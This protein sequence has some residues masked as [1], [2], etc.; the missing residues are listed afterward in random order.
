[1]DVIPGAPTTSRVRAGVCPP[2]TSRTWDGGAGTLEWSAATNWSGDALPSASDQVCI[3]LG[4]PGAEVRVAGDRSIAG[5]YAEKPLVVPTGSLAIAQASQVSSLTLGTPTTSADLSTGAELRVATLVWNGGRISGSGSLVETSS[6]TIAGPRMHSLAIPFTSNGSTVV[7]ASDGSFVIEGSTTWTNNG[8]LH[9]RGGGGVSDDGGYVQTQLVNAPGSRIERLLLGTP[10]DGT[11]STVGVP[12]LNSGTVRLE[13]GTT[14]FLALRQLSGAIWE[15]PVRSD[16]AGIGFGVADGAITLGG[17]LAIQS[18]PAFAPSAGTVLTFATGAISG[19]DFQPVTGT[20]L[21]NALKLRAQGGALLGSLLVD[22]TKADLYVATTSPTR[23]RFAG[24]ELTVGYSIAAL[25]GLDGVPSASVS[26]A[27][28]VG[29]SL[30]E[31]QQAQG[32]CGT[33]NPVVCQ[34]GPIE[35][36]TGVDVAL[37][38]LVASTAPLAITATATASGVTDVAPANNAA[39]SQIPAAVGRPEL[40]GHTVYGDFNNDGRP[41]RA[42]F[43]SATATWWVSLN[44]GGTGFAEP[45]LWANLAPIATGGWIRPRVGKFTGTQNSTGAAADATTDIAIYNTGSLRWYVLRSDGSR[46]VVPSAS[47]QWIT[48]SYQPSYVFSGEFTGDSVDDLAVYE[49]TNRIWRLYKSWGTKF[50]SLSGTA[51]HAF[52]YTLP[53]GTWTQV[54]ALVGNFVGTGGANGG[55]DDIA[56][57]NGATGQWLVL[58]ATTLSGG[59]FVGTEFGSPLVVSSTWN[60]AVA[61]EF[62]GSCPS[63]CNTDIATWRTAAAVW[64][65]VGADGLQ[66][67]WADLAPDGSTNWRQTWAGDLTGD[68]RADVLNEYLASG[69]LFG[70]VATTNSF[71]PRSF[72]PWLDLNPDTGW[73][74][75]LAPDLT[76]DGRSDFVAVYTS[77]TFKPG[78]LLVAP[79][80]GTRFVTASDGSPAAWGSL[81]LKLE[82]RQFPL[83]STGATVVGGTLRLRLT[84]TNPNPFAATITGPNST[85]PAGFAYVSGT[86]AGLTTANPSI[87]GSKLTWAGTFTIP[88]RSTIALDYTIRHSGTTPGSFSVATGGTVAPVSLETAALPVSIVASTPAAQAWGCGMSSFAVDPSIAG[89]DG[90]PRDQGVVDLWTGGYTLGSTDLALPGPGDDFIFSRCYDSANNGVG[91]MG[92]GWAHPYALRL[93]NS[94]TNG[95]PAAGVDLT[96][97]AEDGQRVRFRYTT[98]GYVAP[99][100]ARAS[101]S[102]TTGGYVART[103]TQHQ[104]TF[105]SDGRLLSIRDRNGLGPTLEYSAGTGRLQ[106]VLISGTSVTVRHNLAGLVDRVALPDGRAWTYTY[107]NGRLASATSPRGATTTY[108]YTPTPGPGGAP[109]GLLE[110][111]VAPDGNLRV[112]VQYSSAGRV[113]RQ[114]TFQSVG[115]TATVFGWDASAGVASVSD[116]TGR[117][118]RYVFDRT[119]G[120]LIRQEQPTGSVV[121]MIYDADMNLLKNVNLASGSQT[122]FTYDARGNRLSSTDEF[123]R[124]SRATWTAFNDLSTSTDALGNTTTFSYDSAGNLISRANPGDAEASGGSVAMTLDPVT[125]LPSALTDELGNA[126]RFEYNSFGQTTKATSPAGRITRYEYDASGRNVATIDPLGRRITFEYDA[127]DHVVRSTYV[128]DPAAPVNRTASW[129]YD[130]AGN[131][132]SETD[133]NGRTTTMEYDRSGRAVATVAP[134][135]TRTYSAFDTRGNMV[136]AG[137]MTRWAPGEFRLYDQHITTYTYDAGNRLIATTEPG[138]RTTVTTYDPMTGGVAT[139]QV[140]GSG[141]IYATTTFRYDEAGQVVRVISTP[142]AGSGAV[143]APDVLYSYDALGRRTSVTS[144]DT[145]QVVSYTDRGRI[146]SITSRGLDGTSQLFTYDYDLAGRMVGMTLPSDPIC[147]GTSPAIGYGY[148]VDGLLVSL[149]DTCGDETSASFYTDAY[150]FEYDAASALTRTTLPS[151]ASQTRAYDGSGRLSLVTNLSALGATR[152]RFGYTYDAAGNVMTRSTTTGTTSYQYDLAGRLTETCFERSGNTCSG[153][154]LRW[155]YD[156]LGNRTSETRN[157]VTTT[158]VYETGSDRLIRTV[159]SDAA[160]TSYLYDRAGNIVR[161]DGPGESS[162]YRFDTAGRLVEA[163]TGTIRTRYAMD[164]DGM[165]IAETV[166]APTCGTPK[167]LL[168]DKAGDL[169][170]L[171]SERQGASSARYVRGVGLLGA[172]VRGTRSFYQTDGLGSVTDVLG[173]ADQAYWSLDYEPFG[174]T[175]FATRLT[176]AAPVQP[177]GFTGEYLDSTTGLYHLRARQ[178][179]PKL[180]RFLSVDPVRSPGSPYAY[181][182]NDPLGGTDPSG[183]MHAADPGDSSTAF[184]VSTRGNTYTVHRSNGATQTY[185]RPATS[186]SSSSSQVRHGPCYMNVECVKRYQR[187]NCKGP[188][189]TAACR[190]QLRER[191]SAGHA[192][193]ARRGSAQ[194]SG[195]SAGSSRKTPKNDDDDRDFCD[196]W[197]G[198]PCDLDLEPD[199]PPPP[200]GA[201]SLSPSPTRKKVL[202]TVAVGGTAAIVCVLGGCEVAAAVVAAVAARQAVMWAGRRVVATVAVR[203]ID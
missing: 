187:R 6:G 34:L 21:P 27:L 185:T 16:V 11:T 78:Q 88:A 121:G 23:S 94:A 77:G 8:A 164:A 138:G 97:V 65:V 5:I 201:P 141:G 24:E 13:V 63:T 163:T 81:P 102:V 151:G 153:G 160:A 31:T 182:D 36:G 134:D 43:I 146:A 129:T 33:G 60:K 118:W 124:V 119:T 112:R 197:K 150:S 145:T 159:P 9:F 71:S 125:K 70:G 152:S 180:G 4:S 170:M 75:G 176:G 61:G 198:P 167:H 82:G 133:P 202:V 174:A 19:T 111:V 107:N 113:L 15:L 195:S 69:M 108:T 56:T 41:D 39:S 22:S 40:P 136:E 51:T 162:S 190:Q 25:N 203:V 18:S 191:R 144:G 168:W 183:E 104:Y 32:T 110:T 37:R 49:S 115:A 99:P 46:F 10:S 200:G 158:Y 55:L 109:V 126:W 154:L 122:S 3:L 50:G 1:M 117:P 7:D 83:G 132:T 116:G 196:Y 95:A 96:I 57:F 120:S 184:W 73:S 105:A 123:G 79:S 53:A 177:F 148:D 74:G 173:V 114:E 128:G 28:P 87:S 179:S 147:G 26:F 161:V 20:S 194:N 2:G 169:P 175:R 156:P 30:L 100:G 193:N 42:D 62:D 35:A 68:G 137:V 186:S 29:V 199:P 72:S 131:Q 142:G 143:K 157:G 139:E 130:I 172:N 12:V 165:R 58:R 127:D 106:R 45:R 103:V 80:N 101:L 47:G 188:Y 171:V 52:S 38:V 17:A 189:N 181:V 85:L 135:G 67:R 54:P 178:Y 66:R 84:V 48:L 92:P 86:T 140:Q 166:C 44:V 91:P 93:M 89:E 149:V 192:S 14:R 59:S 90:A 155:T 76:G 64:W 98:T